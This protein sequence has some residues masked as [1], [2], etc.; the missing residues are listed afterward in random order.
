MLNLSEFIRVFHFN[1]YMMY[2]CLAGR[3]HNEKFVF[4]QCSF[5]LHVH[6]GNPSNKTL[7]VGDRFHKLGGGLGFWF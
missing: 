2:T 1:Q 4:G 5:S 7:L 3:L 6:S